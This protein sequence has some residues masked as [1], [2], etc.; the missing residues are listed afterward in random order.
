MHQLADNNQRA[1]VNVWDFLSRE[2]GRGGVG[3]SAVRTGCSW[4]L[5]TWI[6]GSV[7]RCAL[8]P[9]RPPPLLTAACAEVSS[10]RV[11]AH[12]TCARARAHSQRER[13]SERERQRQGRDR[14]AASAA[15]EYSVC[16]LLQLSLSSKQGKLL[17]PPLPIYS[18]SANVT[19]TLDGKMNAPGCK[20][21]EEGIF[22]KTRG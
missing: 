9:P 15:H 8:I 17:P 4:G 6:T 22:F 13:E 10:G 5:T 2:G 16:K 18:M 11:T 20:R 14:V 1:P 3:G 21:E 7:C 12:N 19:S